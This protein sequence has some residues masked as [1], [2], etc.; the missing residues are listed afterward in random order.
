MEF[1]Y[2]L[3]SIRC[4][5]LDAVMSV[6]TY[7]GSEALFMVA[8][9][10]TFWCIDKKYGYYVLT[11]GFAGT[12]IS[13]LLKLVFRIPRPWVRDPEFTIVESARADA[14]GYSFPSGH[15]Q[16]V[17]SYL[18][19]AAR[20]TKKTVW[21]II[22]IILILLTAFSRMYLGVHT[23][24]DVLTGLITGAI[25][26]LV[27]YPVFQKG[28]SSPKFMYVVFSIMLLLS[29]AYTAFTELYPWPADIDPENLAEGIKNGWSLT[30]ACAGMFLSY[31][32]DR[33]YINFKTEAP[34]PAQ[35]FKSVFGIVIAVAVK[36]VLKAPFGFIFRGSGAAHGLRYF[37]M[38]IF[39]ACLWPMLFP[40]ISA[41]FNRK[42][43]RSH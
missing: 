35:I 4:P 29:A 25:L 32:I 10:V 22:L 11:V 9:L 26:V 18:G 43:Q 14:G 19:C 6:I 1:L 5:F 2:V 30:G 16:N 42:K 31:H 37:I 20:V 39:A 12:I 34:L 8:A 40:R 36:T 23:P 41:L 27:L 38:V 24:A 28:Y 21:R 17:T 15:T 3:E 7:L 33:K 13:Q